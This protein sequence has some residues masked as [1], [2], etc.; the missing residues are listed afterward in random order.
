MSEGIV[1]L[2]LNPAL[3]DH[4]SDDLAE[5]LL[6]LEAKIRSG[7]LEVPRGAF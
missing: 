7:E 5:E 3:R 6:A 4:I 1:A 2:E